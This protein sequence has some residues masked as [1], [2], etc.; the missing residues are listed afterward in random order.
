MAG[1]ALLN[2]IFAERLCDERRNT[3]ELYHSA[4]QTANVNFYQKKWAIDA[5]TQ[6]INLGV[7]GALSPSWGYPGTI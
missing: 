3:G 7:A 6:C 1:C 5:P 4:A 2:S